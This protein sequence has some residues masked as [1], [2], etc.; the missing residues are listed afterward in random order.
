[1][2]DCFNPHPVSLSRPLPSDYSPLPPPPLLVPALSLQGAVVPL[3]LSRAVF[4][5]VQ[6][7]GSLPE[8]VTNIVLPR[9]QAGV[10]TIIIIIIII[11]IIVNYSLIRDNM[12]DEEPADDDMGGHSAAE[13]LDV[14]LEL[15]LG[16]LQCGVQGLL[17][18]GVKRVPGLRWNRAVLQRA[19]IQ[20]APCLSHLVYAQESVLRR[21]F[22]LSPPPP[23]PSETR[24]LLSSDSSSMDPALDTLFHSS[25]FSSGTAI[26]FFRR[27]QPLLVAGF[28]CMGLVTF[29]QFWSLTFRLGLSSI[30]SRLFCLVG[31]LVLMYTSEF[32]MGVI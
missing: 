21:G 12:G 23:L 5:T 27:I 13:C 8:A 14:S 6:N 1:M 15:Q 4:L 11:I 24:L 17:W 29:R 2:I 10:I 3:P 30:M 19:T 16:L 18:D 25:F 32:W 31:S 9:K 7:T 22:F 28:V 26:L 20:G